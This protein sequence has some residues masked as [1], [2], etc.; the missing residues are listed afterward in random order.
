MQFIVGTGWPNILS[1]FYLIEATMILIFHSSALSQ[2]LFLIGI[3]VISGIGSMKLF[4]F[5]VGGK[6]L[7][8]LSGAIY[9]LSPTLLINMFV[10]GNP[11]GAW[12]Y[13]LIPWFVLFSIRFI[14]N[15]KANDLAFLVIVMILN[16]FL[17]PESIVFMILF[18]GIPIFFVYVVFLRNTISNAV[19]YLA[20]MLSSLLFLGLVMNFPSLSFITDTANTLTSLATYNSYHAALASPLGLLFLDVPNLGFQLYSAP[21]HF[22]SISTY[23]LLVIGSVE[24]FSVI[25]IA[26]CRKSL[27]RRTVILIIAFYIY[28]ISI[29]SL[30]YYS[31]G[32]FIMSHFTFLYAVFPEYFLLPY[33]ITMS[34]LIPLLLKIS[35]RSSGSRNR[36]FSRFTKKR[37]VLRIFTFVIVILMIT[38]VAISY[39]T[40]G[41]FMNEINKFQASS[42]YISP[43]I[44]NAS[45]ELNV[46]RTKYNMSNSYDLWEPLNGG[47]VLQSGIIYEDKNALAFPAM[48]V[49]NYPT[50]SIIQNAYSYLYKVLTVMLSNGTDVGSL[51]SLIN[52][53][54][55]VVL[56]NVSFNKQYSDIFGSPYHGKPYVSAQ[57]DAIVG[58]PN[59]LC[60]DLRNQSSLLEV[61]NTDQYSIFKNLDYRGLFLGSQAVLRPIAQNNL[62]TTLMQFQTL[63]IWNGSSPIVLS[64]QNAGATIDASSSIYPLQVNNIT[65]MSNF[66]GIQYLDSNFLEN[67]S[68]YFKEFHSDGSGINFKSKVLVNALDNFPNSTLLNFSRFINGY[69]YFSNGTFSE[70]SSNYSQLIEK[71]L[72][73]SFSLNVWVNASSLAKEINGTYGYNFIFG[74]LRGFDL[75]TVNGILDGTLYSN[76][77]GGPP[78]QLYYR[79]HSHAWYMVTLNYNG[80]SFSMFVNGTKVGSVNASGIY[81]NN[82]D[83][84]IGR[85]P[86]Y[87]DPWNGLIS[88]LTLLSKPL[89]VS[90]MSNLFTHGPS[91]YDSN[92]SSEILLYPL[93]SSYV[94]N[95]TIS[96][97][98][99]SD[100]KYEMVEYSGHL[101][102]YMGPKNISMKSTSLSTETFSINSSGNGTM[103]ISS[104]NG[105]LYSLIGIGSGGLSLLTVLKTETVSYARSS[106]VGYFVFPNGDRWI[107]SPNTFT[108]YLYTNISSIKLSGIYGGSVIYITGKTQVSIIITYK[109]VSP[110]MFQ[111]YGI[112]GFVISSILFYLSGSYFTKKWKQFKTEKGKYHE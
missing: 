9:G 2:I 82:F 45:R 53:G 94:K 23:L 76:A 39:D 7:K 43:N 44:I 102:I 34:L 13:M 19:I 51:L 17:T 60:E 1:P 58:S 48:N 31:S 89:S 83:F 24:L 96:L 55:I 104:N 105:T 40:S 33:S 78:A 61:S 70:I 86:V 25:L 80:S 106:S 95:N 28:P 54:F 69:L 56:K 63:P 66:T 107:Y 93:T 67:H 41:G 8:I 37:S 77:S 100:I 10:G 57:L 18:F 46:L 97:K 103:L 65:Y 90:A 68:K 16:A 36:F 21:Y 12:W 3:S 75:S 49:A 108:P 79:I 72:R 27:P 50:S 15:R 38:P 109:G 42:W 88:G 99:P 110:Q 71:A 92:L 47:T 30:I 111:I 20:L 98:I 4:D 91:Y 32:Y 26:I 59:I 112:L 6:Y 74:N 14:E 62:Q 5:L 22:V 73:D 29:L 85:A 101:N 87:N 11:Y 52:V 35:S 81:Y 84:Q 64:N